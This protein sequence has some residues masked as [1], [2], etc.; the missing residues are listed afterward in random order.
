MF[1]RRS[2]TAVIAEKSSTGILLWPWAMIVLS[3]AKMLRDRARRRH[4]LFATI[5]VFSDSDVLIEGGPELSHVPFEGA[6]V[7]LILLL[8]K[9]KQADSVRQL[10]FGCKHQVGGFTVQALLLQLATN[11]VQL[12]RI[13]AQ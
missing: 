11:P 9:E 5:G 6:V 12:L 10:A 1:P 2:A 13:I 7:S 3:T 8:I 4:C